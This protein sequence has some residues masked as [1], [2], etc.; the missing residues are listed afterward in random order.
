MKI[1]HTR[2]WKILFTLDHKDLLTQPKFTTK[3]GF[4]IQQWKNSI[5]AMSSESGKFP[6]LTNKRNYRATIELNGLSV[7]KDSIH[8]RFTVKANN[9]TIPRTIKSTDDNA[10]SF[11]K[12]YK[13]KSNQEKARQTVLD[14]AHRIMEI[15]DMG[16]VP[17]TL[18]LPI[19]M[20]SDA[21][22][23]ILLSLSDKN[24]YINA[25]EIPH[26]LKEYFY[27]M[28]HLLYNPYC[29]FIKSF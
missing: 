25:T 19:P 10:R 13:T 6:G 14:R 3:E 7:F 1:L 4:S 24:I 11:V 21:N 8:P 23:D 9:Q 5:Y 28:L 15:A 2:D 16:R 12:L 17:N 26:Q 20:F 29:R 27:G 22:Y 18:V